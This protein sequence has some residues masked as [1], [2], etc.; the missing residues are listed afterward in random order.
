VSAT[1]TSG[2]GAATRTITVVLDTP[3]AVA[4]ASPAE[5]ERLTDASILVEGTVSDATGLAGVVVN[6]VAADVT[7][8]AFSASVP[9]EIGENVLTATATD[10]FGST[11]FASVTVLRGELPTVVVGFPVDGAIVAASPLEVTGSFTGTAPVSVLVDGIPATVS[12]SSFSASVPLDAGANPITVTAS[13]DFGAATTAVTVVLDG[14]PPSVSIDAP[15]NGTVVNVPLVAIA[16][17]VS[18]ASPIASVTVNGLPAALDGATFT[19]AVTLTPGANAIVATATDAAGNTGSASITVSFVPPP[20]AISIQTPAD[21]ITTTESTVE[22]SGDL[23]RS[24]AEVSVNGVAASV[25][26]TSFHASVALGPLSNAVTAIATLAGETASDSITV[27]RV[28][29]PPPP[30]PP[31]PVATAPPYDPA[32]ATSVFAGTEFLYTGADPIQTD[33]IPGTIEITRSAVIRGSV[34]QRGGAP[35]PSVRVTVKDHPEFGQTL[36]RADGMFDELERPRRGKRLA[37]LR[38][39]LPARDPARQRRL[40]RELRLRRRRSPRAGRR[41]DPGARG[42]DGPAHG[43]EPRLRQHG[44][45]LQR[46][47]GAQ[48]RHGRAGRL[49]SLCQHLSA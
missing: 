20:L 10:S 47:R 23:T 35:L 40:R 28:E 13:N 3:P 36:T 30:P 32:V 1:A 43:H 33:V 48:R 15:A 14:A 19:A 49:A 2:F 42:P 12:G 38:R 8:N 45:R 6:G 27:I 39:L 21:G 4:I 41:R 18:D 5:G 37:D 24:G 17:S 29:T 11:V 25:T 44:G 46:L 34:S 7:G 9:L 16:G 26:G 31:D 22:V